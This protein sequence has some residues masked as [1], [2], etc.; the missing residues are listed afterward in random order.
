MEFQEGTRKEGGFVKRGWGNEASSERE[1][2]VK[3]WCMRRRR[4]VQKEREGRK[5]GRVGQKVGKGRVYRGTVLGQA[6]GK[7][8]GGSMSGRH[9]GSAPI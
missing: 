8:G 4:W 9:G 7:G 6:G 1:K 5:M 2:G 3:R